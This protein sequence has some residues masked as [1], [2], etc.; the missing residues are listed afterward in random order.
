MEEYRLRRAEERDMELL[1]QWA[2]DAETRKNSFSQEAIP[3]QNHALWFRNKLRDK[4]CYFYILTD[5]EQDLGSIRLET[6]PGRETAVI[7]YSVAK[8]HRGKGLGK[9]LL[10]L[11]ERERIDGICFLEGSV[12][13][14]NQSSIKC[15]LD[16]GYERAGEA[17]GAVYF[18][19]RCGK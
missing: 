18:R 3:M 13:K 16:N 8:E 14:Q 2:N 1:Y 7:S 19:K 15:F 12:K 9:K 5:G 10:A 17:D 6:E 4:N 11:A